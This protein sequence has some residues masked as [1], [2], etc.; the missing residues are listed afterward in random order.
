MRTDYIP[1]TGDDA[2]GLLGEWW[3]QPPHL[4]CEGMY[5]PYRGEGVKPS[6]VKADVLVP[7]GK[8]I[9]RYD[10]NAEA[11]LLGALLDIAQNKLKPVEFADQ[12]GLLGYNYIVPRENVCKD[13]DPLNWFLAQARTV[14]VAA[15]LIGRLG[16]AQ[17]SDGGRRFLAEYLKDEIGDGPYSLGGRV[18][19]IRFQQSSRSPIL[20]ANGILR[21]LLNAN[22][23]ETGR[24]IQ[25][26]AS[27]PRTVFTFRALIEVI[28]W[29]LADQ[30]GKDA[31]RRCA[32]CGRIFTGA[33]SRIRFCPP[34]SGQTISPCKSRFNVRRHRKSGKAR[35][36]K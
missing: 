18:T 11:G 31:I 25:I 28:Y 21:Y 8:R 14:Q 36:K 27:G 19:E 29:Q 15:E 32:E 10:P 16:E 1:I 30:I 35:R 24:R 6:I 17:E 9:A 33:N 4:I 20:V 3:R 26:V 34:A 13:G 2:T 23:G 7:R 5:A 12:F 22:L